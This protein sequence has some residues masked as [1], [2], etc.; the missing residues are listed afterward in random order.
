LALDSFFGK[1]S[2]AAGQLDW[3]SREGQLKIQ[4][5]ISSQVPVTHTYNPDYSGDIDQGGL[6]L[7]ASLGK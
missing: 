4:L 1:T 6:W 7:E 5:S 3:Q 2:L